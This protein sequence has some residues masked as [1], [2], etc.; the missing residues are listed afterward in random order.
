MPTEKASVISGRQP[1]TA[2]YSINLKLLLLGIIVFIFSLTCRAQDQATLVGSVTDTTGAV[3]PNAE[4]TVSN[5]DKG[6]ARDL[7][8]NSSG[9][10]T[11]AKIPIGNYVVTAEAPGFRKLLRTGVVLQVGQT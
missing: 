3:V 1:R 4:V 10:F 7:V 6:F 5:P 2:R 9:E 8:T 11:A